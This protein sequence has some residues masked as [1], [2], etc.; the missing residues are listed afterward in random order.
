V[1]IPEQN[2]KDPSKRKTERGT[3]QGNRE[4]DIGLSVKETTHRPVVG[5]QSAAFVGSDCK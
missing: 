2:N 4:Y 5:T 1:G 3:K